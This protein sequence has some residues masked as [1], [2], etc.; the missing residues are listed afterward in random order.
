MKSYVPKWISIGFAYYLLTSLIAVL[1]ALFGS[2]HVQPTIHAHGK[3]RV[4]AAAFAAWD[5]EWY[6]RI[7]QNG[8]SYNPNAPSSVAFFPAYPLIGRFLM[9]VTGWPPE[10]SLL[11]CSHL[12]LLATFIALAAYLESRMAE[13]PFVT[14]DYV[15]LSF[16]LLPTTFFFRM[17]YGESVFLFFTIMALYALERKWHWLPTALV[18]G[19]AT[20]S[21]AVGVLLLVPFA[22]QLARDARSYRHLVGQLVLYLPLASWGLLAY[23]GYQWAEFG[24]P[25]AFAKTQVNWRD[26]PPGTGADKIL[27]LLTL[28]PIWT[29]FDP[30][31]RG[32]WARHQPAEPFFNLRLAN[33]GYFLLA[34]GLIGLG[35]WR[36][37]LSEAEIAFSIPMLLIPYVTRS[38][39]MYMAGTG[40]F[41]ATIVPIYLVLGRL[42]QRAPPGL[43]CALLAMSACLMGVYAALF[44]AWYPF[45]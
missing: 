12:F 44:S 42:L 16:G 36:R 38:Y 31:S 28:E 24:D 11:V 41:M 2:T 6:A 17:V 33:P 1:G 29:T 21:R 18:I 23:M 13:L 15:L 30:A 9:A 8:Y 19:A 32:F 20:A 5:G 3:E 40:R 14:A 10:L 34:I 27:S 43:A 25:L 35:A 37:W 4:G 39:E 7:T 22:L 26:R 45:Y